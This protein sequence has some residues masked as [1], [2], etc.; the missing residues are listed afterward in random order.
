MA[1]AGVPR[2]TIHP[3]EQF[4]V[5]FR[6]SDG[7]N[8]PTGV[9]LNS[10]TVAAESMKTHKDT[11]ADVLQT[12]DATVN[13]SD[14]DNQKVSADVKGGGSAFDD[15][16]HKITITTTLSNTDIYV[17]VFILVVDDRVEEC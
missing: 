16:E 2:V 10:G 3:D 5:S 12:T 1:N 11:S 14:P 7:K 6:Y 13:N 4:A 15:T 17:D 9:T 8:I